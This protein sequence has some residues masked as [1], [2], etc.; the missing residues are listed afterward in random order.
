MDYLHLSYCSP[1][2]YS[3]YILKLFLCLL[4]LRYVFLPISSYSAECLKRFEDSEKASLKVDYMV[5]VHK[6]YSLVKRE[7]KKLFN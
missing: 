6:Y 4:S 2:G 3:L 7:W 1:K 5:D